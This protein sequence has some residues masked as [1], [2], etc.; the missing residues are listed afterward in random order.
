MASR[1]FCTRQKLQPA[2][3]LAPDGEGLGT[4][5]RYRFSSENRDTSPRIDWSSAIIVRRGS[6]GHDANRAN[7]PSS[8]YELN[9]LSG[10]AN[11]SAECFSAIARAAEALKDSAPLKKSSHELSCP[12]IVLKTR[13]R[14]NSVTGS[15][16]GI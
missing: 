3:G 8:K 15:S 13:S 10:S 5:A 11:S 4:S 7:P 16:C 14:A 12:R 1:A 2:A 9:S 6:N